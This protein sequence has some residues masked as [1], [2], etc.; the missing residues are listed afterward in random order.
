MMVWKMFLL[1]QGF[2][3]R[4]H[5]NLARCTHFKC[6]AEMGEDQSLDQFG[7]EA[8][9]A[10]V[11]NTTHPKVNVLAVRYYQNSHGSQAKTTSAVTKTL[12]I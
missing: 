10:C 11:S 12:F 3:L 6:I 1:F 5:V 2:I 9:I 4:F 7:R 8:V